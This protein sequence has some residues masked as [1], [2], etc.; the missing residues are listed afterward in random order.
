MEAFVSSEG[1][2]VVGVTTKKEFLAATVPDLTLLDAQWHCLDLC[3]MAARYSHSLLKSS[4]YFTF[5]F[6][7]KVLS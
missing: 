7:M 2:F 5:M 3:F 6:F 1:S 4:S